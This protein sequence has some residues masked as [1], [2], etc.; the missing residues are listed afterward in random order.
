MHMRT[1]NNTEWGGGG[2]GAKGKGSYEMYHHA[3]LRWHGICRPSCLTDR[4]FY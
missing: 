4:E 3:E 1:L 2:A